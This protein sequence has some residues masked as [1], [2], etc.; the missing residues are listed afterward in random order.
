MSASS[1]VA[2]PV[3]APLALQTLGAALG[4]GIIGDLMLRQMPWGIGV[5]ISTAALVAV[6]SGLVYRHRLAVGPDAPWLALSALLLGIAFVRRDADML[7]FLDVVGL[8]GVLALGALSL[9]GEGLRLRGVVEYL[10]SGV[11]A[12]A[13]A[14][15]GILPL[16][17][18]D[19]R[20]GEVTQSGRLGRARAIALGGLLALPLLVVFAALFASAD[21]TFDALLRSVLVF[22][23]ERVLSHAF[24][25]CVWA[26]LTGGYL[27]GALIRPVASLPREVSTIAIGYVPVA[28]MLG[29]VNL[30]FLVFVVTQAPYFFGGLAV[31]ERT[32]G[33]TLAQFARRGFFELVMVSALVLPVLL[34]SEWALRGAAARELKSFRALAGLL[35]LQVVAVMGSA[36]FRMK[37]YVDQFGPSQDRLYATAFMGYLGIVSV[38]FAWTCLRGGGARSR[39]AF[40]AAVQGY[41]VLALLHV[42]N[43]DGVV[44]RAN[45]A[46]AARGAEFDAHY[47]A[48]E[49]SADAVPALL[50]ALDRL[51]PADRYEVAQQLLN[52]WGPATRPDWRSWNWSAGRARGLVRAAT[53]QLTA[54][55][56]VPREGGPKRPALECRATTP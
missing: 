20:W 2:P 56:C 13:S 49:L 25:I 50:G 1:P 16:T 8:I 31:V 35:L 12:A 45:L 32:T 4:L 5:T 15:L 48:H 53:A 37:L 26:A 23:P 30:L 54:V 52:R 7:H 41:A 21:A 27:R 36:L 9:Q 28:T 14:L 43:V 55:P 33:L 40:G 39:F 17:L 34:A 3:R 22:D 42:V 44:A 46:R 18:S 51:T 19:I 24:Q 47:H 11:L 6:A 29:L 38:W 10:R